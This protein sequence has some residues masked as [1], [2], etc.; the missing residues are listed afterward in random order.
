MSCVLVFPSLPFSL[1]KEEQ[2]CATSSASLSTVIPLGAAEPV[3]E[4]RAGCVPVLLPSSKAMAAAHS[5]TALG[6]RPSLCAPSGSWHTSLCSSLPP[7]LP[8]I[9]PLSHGT[10]LC[11]R[12]IPTPWKYA[13]VKPLNQ[14]EGTRS[15][16]YLEKG[17]AVC[18]PALTHFSGT[19]GT[20]LPSIPPSLPSARGR[21]GRPTQTLRIRACSGEHVLSINKATERQKI[22]SRN[23]KD[24]FFPPSKNSTSPFQ[25][26][27]N[28]EHSITISKHY[29]VPGSAGVS[30][31][32]N[33]C[34]ALFSL[35][36]S[37]CQ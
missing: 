17:C 1:G 8:P 31:N 29:P 15:E 9:D 2:V 24:F 6:S 19:G 32:A 4:E 25:T 3:Q 34:W 28:L 13:A 14:L 37:L 27:I 10:A 16:V 26:L 22:I 18:E 11:C 7:S 36:N 23:T 21:L 35:P 20:G 5:L 30:D 33:V 12:A